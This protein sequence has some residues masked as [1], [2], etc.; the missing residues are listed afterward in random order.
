[1]I[2]KYYYLDRKYT[3]WERQHLVLKKET[4]EEIDTYIKNIDLSSINFHLAEEGQFDEIDVESLYE[5]METLP[6]RDNGYQPTL[7][8]LDR[9]SHETIKDNLK[10]IDKKDVKM[11]SIRDISNLWKLLYGEDLLE[12]YTGFYGNLLNV[13]K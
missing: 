10:D 5:T 12:N 2:E 8:L 13:I 6:L 4:Q 3:I 7:E 9:D 11:F 1:M